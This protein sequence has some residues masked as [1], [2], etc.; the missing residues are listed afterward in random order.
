MSKEAVVADEGKAL[1]AAGE[2]VVGC[3]LGRCDSSSEE[4]ESEG[5]LMRSE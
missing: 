2:L 4:E 3:R 5:D 1:L